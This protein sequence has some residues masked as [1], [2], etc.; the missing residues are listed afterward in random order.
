MILSSV[1]LPHPLGPTTETNSPS[2]AVKETFSSALTGRARPPYVRSTFC[3]EMTGSDMGL[4]R[5]GALF[6]WWDEVIGEDRRRL[7]RRAQPIGL[8]EDVEACH[9]VGF[10]HP[11]KR[12]AFGVL[13]PEMLEG[14][15]PLQLDRRCPLFARAGVADRYL[16]RFRYVLG[17]SS[18]DEGLVGR[19]DEAL[20]SVAL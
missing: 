11:T 7:E 9:P 15:L 16:D 12:L 1:L 3:K 14:V 19:G 13:G 18:F 17:P 20:D 10:A 8:P 6:R 4:S 2:A 5:T